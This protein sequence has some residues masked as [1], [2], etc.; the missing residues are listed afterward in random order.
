[1]KKISVIIIAKDE[2]DL[3]EDCLKSVD[4]VDEI[5]FVDSESKD[6]T[7][8]IAKKYTEK[9]FIKKWEGF[10]NQKRYAL[11]LAGNEFV[12][13]IDAD[14]RVSEN[15][16]NEIQKINSD[17]VA[18]YKIPRENYFFKKHITTCGWDRDYQLRL[19]KKIVQRSLIDSFMKDLRLTAK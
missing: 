3:I 19:F 9:I 11:S 13:S 2:E 4:W 14:E 16:K 1:M 8:E 12:L 5:I 7:V 10:A 15:L 6:N 18:G 17:T